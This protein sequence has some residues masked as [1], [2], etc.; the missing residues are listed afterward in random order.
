MGGGRC[1]FLLLL[2][3]F[4]FFGLFAFLP[5]KDKWGNSKRNKEEQDSEAKAC[6]EVGSMEAAVSKLLATHPSIKLPWWPSAVVKRHL[7]QWWWVTEIAWWGKSRRQGSWLLRDPNQGIMS[8]AMPA[9]LSC[10]ST[11]YQVLKPA[12]WA[13]ILRHQGILSGSG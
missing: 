2:F 11:H 7:C 5:V 3:D 9:I 10:R 4:W 1:C 6:N 12:P 13:L 8:P